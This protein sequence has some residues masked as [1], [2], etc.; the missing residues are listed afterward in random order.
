MKKTL[1]I[2]SPLLF[3]VGCW[4]PINLDKHP[5]KGNT[6]ALEFSTPAKYVMGLKID[7]Q[8]IPISYTG[9]NRVLWVE[10]LSEGKHDFSINS[11]SYVYGPEVGKYEITKDQGA[12]FFI[13]GRKYRSTTPKD[14]ASVSIRAYRKQLKKQGIDAKKGVEGDGGGGK[15]RAYFSH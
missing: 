2:L 12:Y 8:E 15:I 5:I 14:R 11:I 6:L 10:G 9:K 4:K 1:L 13:Q 7:G 3:L